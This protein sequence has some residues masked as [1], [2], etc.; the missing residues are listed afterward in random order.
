MKNRLSLIHHSAFCIHHLL[1]LFVA[2]VPTATTTELAELQTLRRRLLILRRRVITTLAFR[3]LQ[4]NI[5]A[6]HKSPSKLNSPI[7]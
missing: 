5:I 1:R 3:A 4:H 2:R 6:W 7:N